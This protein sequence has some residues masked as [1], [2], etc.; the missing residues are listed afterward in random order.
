MTL[1]EMILLY[2]AQADDKAEPYLAEDELLT[3]YANEAQTEACRRA[4]L[5]RDSASAICTPTVTVGSDVITVDNRIVRILKATVNGRQVG[6]VSGEHMDAMAPNWQDDGATGTPT[7]LIEGVST[8]KLH[9]WPRPDA[10]CAVRLTVQRLPLKSMMSD[11]DKPEIRPELHAA[12]VDWMVHRVFSQQDGELYNPGKASLHL[13]R[14]ESE[15]GTRA[16]G[17]NEA[18]IRN[19]LSVMSQP[20]A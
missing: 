18:W 15:F 2:R 4:E 10:P 8:G 17:R 7:N 5:L 6:I 9:L 1:E 3:L 16:S 13:G 12:L 14:F 19:G 11:A 20:I